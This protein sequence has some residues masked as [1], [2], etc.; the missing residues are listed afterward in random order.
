MN[1]D[2][3]AAFA[4]HLLEVAVA[5]PVATVPAH[6]PEHD[7]ALEGASLEV[8]HGSA[9]PTRT[10]SRPTAAGLA[11]EPDMRKRSENEPRREP[12]TASSGGQ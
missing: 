8:R 4:H 11:T 10:S 1:T 7:R 3:D 5:H 12:G 9:L 2:R 6:R